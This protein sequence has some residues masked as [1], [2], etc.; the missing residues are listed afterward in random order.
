MR[1][2]DKALFVLC[3]ENKFLLEMKI[4]AQ[5]KKGKVIIVIIGF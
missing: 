2:L 5:I 4:A 1:E 3:Q